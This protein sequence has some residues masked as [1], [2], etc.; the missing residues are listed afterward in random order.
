M[1]API[2]YLTEKAAK[3]RYWNEFIETM[4]RAQLDALH[5]Q[6]LQKLVAYVYEYSPF[7]RRRSMTMPWASSPADIRTL[8]DYRRKV[9]ITDKQDFRPVSSRSVRP[10]AT[11]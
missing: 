1:A 2:S 11:P 4:P 9:P 7:Y 10:T 5:L 6:K 3:A 8:E